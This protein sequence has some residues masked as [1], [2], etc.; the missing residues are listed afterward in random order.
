MDV[1]II[2]VNYNTK[3]LTLNCLNS[4]YEK[5]SGIDFEVVIVD[6][7][8]VDGSCDAIKNQ[9]P[10]VKLIENE[11]N[12]GF[13]KANNVGIKLSNAKYVLLL[14]TDTELINNAVK[15]L[16]DLMENDPSIGA[17]GGNLFDKDKNPVHSYGYLNT[18]K[19]FFCRMMG[20]RYL[21]KDQKND[22]NRDRVQ[23]VEQ[24]IG[25]DLML[26]K[27][28]LDKVGAFDERFFLY[29]EESELQFRIS[30]GGYKIIYTPEPEI[31]H[32]EGAATKKNKKFRRQ[33]MTQS[34]Y[35]YFVLSHKD[36]SKLWLRTMCSIPQIYRFI[37]APRHTWEAI[38]YMWTH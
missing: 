14:N 26:R 7:A 6:N 27:S 3:E 33:M 37:C 23:E 15:L 29:C 10:Q 18:P 31:Y 34:Q 5:T 4:I 32:F 13:G 21:L 30:Q 22:A 11:K 2:L 36:V 20:L 8:S 24:I 12:L 38:K 1:S 16:Y 25:A 9:F 19:K 28:A 35:L 17:C